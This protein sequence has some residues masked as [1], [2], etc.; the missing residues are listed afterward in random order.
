MYFS[1][2]LNRFR[3]YW[4]SLIRNVM[5]RLLPKY[6]YDS[7]ELSS[8]DFDTLERVLNSVKTSAVVYR[9]DEL[10]ATTFE[11]DLDDNPE[12]DESG[13]L[14][15]FLQHVDFGPSDE[16][17]DD[18]ETYLRAIYGLADRQENESFIFLLGK[19]TYPI[20]P[21]TLYAKNRIQELLERDLP[22]ITLEACL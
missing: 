4:T 15:I 6:P 11:V 14:T 22:S 10:Q 5:L 8:E 9:P 17:E 16:D 19:I 20:T 13:T 21:K 7:L 1:S 18:P 2:S 3:L 12:L